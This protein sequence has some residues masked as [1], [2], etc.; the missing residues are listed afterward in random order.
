MNEVLILPRCDAIGDKEASVIESFVRGGGT[1]IADVRPAV[2][3]GR[4]KMRKAGALDRLFGVRRSGL[5][6]VKEAKAD[7]A[8]TGLTFATRVDPA[9]A[10]DGGRAQGRA[11]GAPVVISR[12]VGKGRAVLLN[13]PMET[14]PNPTSAS[15]PAF[16]GL[17]ISTT[18]PTVWRARAS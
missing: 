8:A 11:G 2:F 5:A 6:A 17:R 7:L 16:P 1:V 9:V 15:T 3:N 18:F 13:V 10:L 14:W 4:C 12:R